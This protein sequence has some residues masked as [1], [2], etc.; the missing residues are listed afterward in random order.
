MFQVNCKLGGHEIGG[1]EIDNLRLEHNLR[2]L[3]VI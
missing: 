3:K 1:N 2:Y